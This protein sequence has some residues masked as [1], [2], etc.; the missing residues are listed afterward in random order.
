MKRRKKR[1]RAAA[2]AKLAPAETQE[3]AAVFLPETNEERQRR[4]R[5]K[6]ERTERRLEADPP[7][8][9][10]T[11]FQELLEQLESATAERE[12]KRKKKKKKKRKRLKTSV[13]NLGSDAAAEPSVSDG[14]VEHPVEQE[15]SAAESGRD[16]SVVESMPALEGSPEASPP[17]AFQ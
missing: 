2:V 4:K 8:S 1:A 16:A 10:T 7:Q 17:A 5:L 6:R 11:G 13:I 15:R 9:A 14:L 12:G 3:A